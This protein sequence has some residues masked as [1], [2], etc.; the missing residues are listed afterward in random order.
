MIVADTSALV[1][2]D[3]VDLLATTLDEFEVHTTEAVLVELEETAAYD[4]P[5][6]TA[7]G[8]VLEL[9]DGLDVHEIGDTDLRSSRI[10][11]GEATCLALE[12]ELDADFL[13]TDD[14]RALPEL[15][16]LADAR[17]A[18]SPILLRALV[19]RGVL[20]DAEARERLDRLARTR[21]WLGAPII[22]RALDLFDG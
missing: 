15:Q 2:V 13:L 10:D 5:H 3:S 4:D 6:G 9:T 22:R 14:L 19:E 17:V 7:A 18:I 16:S 20:A 11:E 1:S 8:R 12:R 21:D